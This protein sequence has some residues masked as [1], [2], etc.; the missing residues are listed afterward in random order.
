[1]KPLL[2]ALCLFVVGSAF[3]DDKGSSKTKRAEVPEPD[4]VITPNTIRIQSLAVANKGYWALMPGF[5]ELGSPCFSRDGEWI[6][7]DAYKM[8]F[9]NSPSEC[10]IA[11]RNG[12]DLTRLAIGAT[13]RWSPDGKQIVFMRDVRNLPNQ[14]SGVFVIRRDGTGEKRIGEGRWPD[15]SPDGKQ[16]AFSDGGELTGGARVGATIWI[17]K[18]D[19]SSRREVAA[20]DCPSWSPDGRKLSLCLRE[21][22]AA[23]IMVA[24]DLET[25]K[26]AA[27][28]V[29][30]Y[31]GHWTP[32]SKSVV[33]NGV[34]GREMRMVKLYLDKPFRQTELT[35]EFAEPFSP[36][37]SADGK[38]L[39]FIAKRPKVEPRP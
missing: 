20:G 4:L 5:S 2:L 14:S 27:I 34:V 19:G 31:R 1:M 32:D 22:E 9:N 7:F 15:W 17:A 37:C 10:W 30:W 12:K 38:D 35:T 33:C 29:G 13:P 21:P 28:G 24:F 39:V 11:R 23:P 25:R 3:A 18:A 26:G 6:A 8:G 36:S 16:I